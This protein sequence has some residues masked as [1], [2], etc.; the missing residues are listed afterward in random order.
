[1]H[2]MDGHS[3][4]DRKDN[5]WVFFVRFVPFLFVTFVIDYY[6]W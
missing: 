3:T 4:K 1:M 2:E 5:T 6:A